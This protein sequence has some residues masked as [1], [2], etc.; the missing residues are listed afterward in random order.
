[1]VA[2]G[3]ECQ[4]TEVTTGMARG[5]GRLLARGV[6]IP[7]LHPQASSSATVMPVDLDQRCILPP[8]IS[9]PL[10]SNLPVLTFSGKY[11]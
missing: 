8:F 10:V 3:E 2:S 7:T 9:N 11:L 4:V 6:G 5:V 1:M